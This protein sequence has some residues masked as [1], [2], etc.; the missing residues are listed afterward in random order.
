[1]NDSWPPEQEEILA[2]IGLT[3]LLLQDLEHIFSHCMRLIFGDKS[4]LTLNDFLAPE[5]RTLG[6]MKRQLGA[7]VILDDDFED[8][9][10][11]LV[12]NRNILVHHL[13]DQAWFNIETEEGRNSTWR[14]LID[15]FH[16]IESATKIFQA[17]ALKQAKQY[18]FHEMPYGKEL[19][20][21]GIFQN[22]EKNYFP[23]IDSLIKGRK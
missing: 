11:R 3:L 5:K 13:N 6:T 16:Q 18:G 7:A 10:K 4:I 8:L 17:F 1:M 9:L 15:H 20:A 12:N 22:L 23:Y 19:Q 2:Q 14:F 21:R